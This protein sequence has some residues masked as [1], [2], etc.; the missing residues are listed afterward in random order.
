V[1]LLMFEAIGDFQVNES[2]QRGRLLPAV[3]LYSNYIP[4]RCILNPK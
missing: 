3:G 2:S 1:F 4:W